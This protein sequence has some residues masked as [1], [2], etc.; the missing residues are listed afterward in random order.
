LQNEGK[1][2]FPPSYTGVY[3]RQKVKVNNL[4]R[5]PLKF[6]IDIPEK[7]SEELYL[8]FQSEFINPNESIFLDCS[9]IPYKKK[10]YKIKI[11][12][13]AEEIIDPN[14]NLIGYHIPGSGNL[15]NP[16]K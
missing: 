6:T 10:D 12:L 2:Y 7:Y 1:I 8:K 16:L 11:P 5:I 3:S 13:I 14:Q 9:F 4:S 15:D